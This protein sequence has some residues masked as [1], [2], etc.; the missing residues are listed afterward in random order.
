MRVYTVHLRRFGLDPERDLVLVKEG[1]SWPALVF[2]VLW[3]L[4]HRM[5]VAAAA[6]VAVNAV[7]FGATHWIGLDAAGQL[8]IDVAVALIVGLVGNDLRR[9]SLGRAGYVEVDVVAGRNAE[10]AEQRFLDLDPDLA[11]DLAS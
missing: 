2:S 1:F 4:W 11:A 8:A 3:A 10:A 5:W 7:L 6:L 9:W